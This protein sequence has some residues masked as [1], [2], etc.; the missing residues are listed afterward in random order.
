MLSKEDLNKIITLVSRAGHYDLA[1]R[2]SME[3][4]SPA[5][6]DRAW[7]LSHPNAP[8]TNVKTK[9]QSMSNDH[10]IACLYGIVSHGYDPTD[11]ITQGWET[12]FM[13]DWHIAV[14]SELDRRESLERERDRIRQLHRQ[15]HN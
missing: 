9:I 12:V 7:K 10:L 6:K 14:H 1:E 11:T 3:L 15:G 2:V 5:D 8:Y 4:K 13:E